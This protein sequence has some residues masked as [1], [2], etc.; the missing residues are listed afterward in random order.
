MEKI[1]T[2]KCRLLPSEAVLG[3]QVEVPT[4]DGR[5][6]MKI[7]PGVRF[8]QR[9]RLAKT[10]VTPQTTADRGDQLVEIQ[11]VCP[12]RYQFPKNRNLYEQVASRLKLLIPGWICRCRDRGTLV[13]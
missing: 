1:F 8:G 12:Q 6:N 3:G 10:R 4:L 2:A 11:I 13:R 5:V 7:P 9:L